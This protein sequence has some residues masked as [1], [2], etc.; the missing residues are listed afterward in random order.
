MGVRPLFYTRRNGALYFASEAKALL[1]VPGV[2]A[3]LDP[4]ALDQIFTFWFPLAPRT[5]F[6]GIEE[7]E[8]AHVLLADA[9]GTVVR[10][11]WSL[12]YPRL[13]EEGPHDARAEAALAE[14]VEHLLADATRIR[15]RA[16]V[17]VGSYLSGGLGS[18]LLAAAAERFVPEPPP[19]LSPPLPEPRVRRSRPSQGE[20]GRARHGPRERRLH[21]RRHRPAVSAG[22]PS[23][24]KADPAHRA[25]AAACAFRSRPFE[26]LQGRAHRRRRRRGV[27]RLRHL[28]GS[29][30]A[31][32]L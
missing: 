2:C 1:E 22:D 23:R 9:D 5:V 25:G 30:A 24:R 3:E 10:P 26:R 29:E 7:L 32:L 11:Y 31:P 21:L 15:L 20:G 27:R 8:P 4:I 12:D 13:G 16:D 17:P 6:K 14:E 18:S 28:Q 19:A